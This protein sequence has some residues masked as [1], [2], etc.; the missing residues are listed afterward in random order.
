MPVRIAPRSNGHES[1]GLFFFVDARLQLS[2][3]ADP[4]FRDNRLSRFSAIVSVFLCSILI[5]AS[6]AKSREGYD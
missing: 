5:R 1:Q 2:S 6:L 4:L 3:S